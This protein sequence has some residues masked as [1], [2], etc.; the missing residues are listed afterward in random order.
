MTGTT[1]GAP[2]R[3]YRIQHRTVYRYSDEVS[4]SFGRGYLRPREIPDGQRCLSYSLAIEPEP[5][6]L[7]HDIDVYGNPNTY[8]HVTTGHTELVVTGLS[9]VEVQRPAFDQ[10]VLD[11]PW[12]QARPS[13]FV[14]PRAVEFTLA[15]PLVRMPLQVHEYALETFTPHRP[16]IDAVRDLTHRI[17]T[18]FKYHPGS[19]SVSSTVIDVLEARSGVCQD[20]AHLA[21]ACLRSVGLACRYVSGYLATDPPPGKERMIGVDAS[22]AWAAVRLADGRWLGFDPTND[23]FADERYTIVAWGRDYDDVPPLRGVIYTDA[24]SNELDVSVDV[25]PLPA[26]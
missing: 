22:H 13:G 17:F 18:G 5:S 4:T 21:V 12:E 15:S 16:I 3:R 14:D 20:F 7:T 10:A 6:D 8:F 2:T 25:A 19:T 1:T 26:R 9:E 24:E 11:L 23:A